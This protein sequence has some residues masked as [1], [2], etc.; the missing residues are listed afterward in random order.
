MLEENL[1]ILLAALPFVAAGAMASLSTRAHAAAAWV[2]G[3]FVVA[4]M[5]ILAVLHGQVAAGEVL[6]AEWEWVPALGLAITF[7]MDALV[8]LMVSLVFGIG[9]L[10][11]IYARYYLTKSDPVPRFYAFLMGFAGAMVG[12]LMSGNIL[13]LLVFWE[14]TSVLSFLLVGY[15]HQTQNARDGARTALVVT[16][17]RGL[18]LLLAMLMIG[19]IAGSYDLDVVLG[20]GDLVRADPAYPLILILFLLGCFPKSAQMPFHF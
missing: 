15:W 19:R 9:L 6:R 17:A 8:W 16:G 12:V 11:L 20:A 18:C 14:L 13:M 10:V 5:G 1:L 4:G 3:V 2:C 7:R